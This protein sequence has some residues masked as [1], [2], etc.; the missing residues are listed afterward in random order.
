[1]PRSIGNQRQPA[2]QA[3]PGLILPTLTG[4]KKATWED[5]L[6]MIGDKI[7]DKAD[8]MAAEGGDPL[9]AIE[10]V[11]ARKM[12]SPLTIKRPRDLAQNWEF[13]DK[14]QTDLN[15]SDE[16]FPIPVETDDELA[17]MMDE[18]TLTDWLNEIL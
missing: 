11:W 13:Q 15:L 6:H 16:T 10:E 1:M 17:Q 8:Q 14:I 9:A 4:L 5:V 18:E 7:Q 3:G 12:G 2:W